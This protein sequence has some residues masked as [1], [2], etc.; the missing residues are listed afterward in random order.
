MARIKKQLLIFILFGVN[1]MLLATGCSQI[2]PDSA[3]SFTESKHLNSYFTKQV[4]T[5]DSFML[6]SYVGRFSGAGELFVYIE[7]DGLAWVTRSKVSSNP[8]PRNPVALK[9]ALR[10]MEAT[11]GEAEIVYLARPCQFVE[12]EQQTNCSPKFWTDARFSS[13]VVRAMSQAIDSLKSRAAAT[14]LTLIGY[15]GGG[16]IAS[17]ISA[18]R[19]DVEML[20]TVAG[21]LDHDAW[22]S[23]HRVSPLRRSL[24]AADFID[25]ISDIRQV[26]F[27][28][29][30]DTVMPVSIIERF[31]L[32]L[33]YSKSARF[34]VIPELDHSCCWS[35]IWPDLLNQAKSQDK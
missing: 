5:T 26:H 16:A 1:V 32:P 28:G 24:N 7:G 10:H 22:T 4:I 13:E 17:L 14:K 6:A 3:L 29:A 9:L 15:S 21:N 23:Y 11:N 34:I 31:R 20:I 30:E 35:V 8:T 33:R 2:L 25:E 27:I 18:H 19:N 12:P